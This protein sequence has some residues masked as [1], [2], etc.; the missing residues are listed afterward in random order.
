MK[1]IVVIIG[2]PDIKEH[3]KLKQKMYIKERRD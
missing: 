1:E 3:H 2:M